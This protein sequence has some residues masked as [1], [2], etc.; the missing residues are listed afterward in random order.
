MSS[1]PP[2]APEP[3]A[4]L[5]TKRMLRLW[6]PLAA[7]WLLMA[8]EL[9]IFA[10]FVARMADE[11]IHLAAYSSIVF[12]VSLVIEGPII[13]LLAASTALSTNWSNY[14][15]LRRFMNVTSALLTTIHV[16]VAFTPLF[17]FVA[18]RLLGAPA[19]VIEPARIGLRIMTPWT[20][21]IAYRRFQQGLLIRFER[22]RAVVLGTAVRLA[23][24]VTVFS[25]GYFLTDLSGI[26]VGTCAVA[27][28]VTAEAI[29]AGW[30]VRPVLRHQL[31]LPDLDSIPLTRRSFARFYFPLAL[32]PL[33]T[34]LIQPMGS[35]AMGRMPHDI[36][37]LAA[38]PAVFGLVFIT[39]ST[40]FALNEVVVTFLGV[41]GAVP[42]LRRFTFRLAAVCMGVLVLL[43]LTP[44]A[45]FWFADV[46]DLEPELATLGATAV[47]FAVLMP[48][49]QAI[50]SWYQGALVHAHETR[51]ITEAVILYILISGTSLAIGV[52]HGGVPGIYWALCSFSLG[53]VLQTSW[54]AWRSRKVIRKLC[55]DVS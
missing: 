40:G 27:T 13:M 46:S 8:G 2:L 41:R 22:S 1:A 14:R 34:L 9:P 12:P 26:V 11:K 43:A 49:Y 25:I 47:I 52:A 39:R 29:F 21:A 3:A 36:D 18:V 38:W 16:L 19:E 55:Q 15:K 28:S 10:A 37:S 32:T 4:P 54:L 48:G 7:S 24:N 31:P 42:V 5:T 50:Q 17:D 20:W 23:S 30:C 6:W 53:G 33:L 45:H 51:P 35:A 44:L